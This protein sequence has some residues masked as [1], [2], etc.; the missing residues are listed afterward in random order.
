MDPSAISTAIWD[1]AIGHL[2]EI[3]ASTAPEVDRDRDR[4]TSFRSS[5]HSAEEK[6]GS[7]VAVAAVIEKALTEKRPD[8]R[9]VVGLS[10]K[11]A[12]ALKPLVP[13]RVAD[14][15]AERVAKP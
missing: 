13:D 11:L 10:G 8:T 6:G 14:K 1:K 12:T 9:D 3:L 15:L 5:L 2:D 4:L 7:P